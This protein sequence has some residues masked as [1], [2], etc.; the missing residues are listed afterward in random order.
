MILG[1][2]VTCM[3]FMTAAAHGQLPFKLENPEQYGSG[4]CHNAVRNSV[5]GCDTYGLNQDEVLSTLND[6][7]LQVCRAE[8]TECC[9]SLDQYGDATALVATV[10]EFCE[11]TS[12]INGVVAC[13]WET[14]E[15]NMDIIDTLLLF[16][17]LDGDAFEGPDLVF[18]VPSGT[19]QDGDVQAIWVGTST[20]SSSSMLTPAGANRLRAILAAIELI[21][22]VCHVG[23]IHIVE[24]MEEQCHSSCGAYFPNREEIDDDPSGEHPG[25]GPAEGPD[26][27]PFGNGNPEDGPCEMNAGATCFHGGREGTL[28]PDCS[29]EPHGGTVTVTEGCGDGT[30]WNTP[31]EECPGHDPTQSQLCF[32]CNNDPD[33]PPSCDWMCWGF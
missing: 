32:I 10:G 33:P 30:S 12:Q 31:I 14:L 20:V 28:Q 7:Q 24:A 22:H 26:D 19:S 2:F 29:C 9:E 23:S 11:C 15:E 8:C 1:F 18:E 16:G 17:L 5:A 13:L 6:E 3:A 27:D 4:L 25:N 21:S